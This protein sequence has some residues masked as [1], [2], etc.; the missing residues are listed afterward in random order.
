MDDIVRGLIEFVATNLGNLSPVAWY[1]VVAA[2]ILTIL[3]IIIP[4]AF[5]MNR[6]Y[7]SL[8]EDRLDKRSDL[9]QLS[10]QRVKMLEET[11]PL[12]ALEK[13]SDKQQKT[14]DDD[15]LAQLIDNLEIEDYRFLARIGDKQ[16][17][18]EELQKAVM[19]E[20]Y[21]YSTL[22]LNKVENLTDVQEELMQIGATLGYLFGLWTGLNGLLFSID[23]F[24]GPVE[25]G[26]RG[27]KIEHK[28]PTAVRQ[29][30]FQKLH[31]S[32]K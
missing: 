13:E 12:D 1:V 19:E 7:R 21:I 18:L 29:R 30:I 4:L 9:L 3:I 16:L 11:S 17:D 14:L 31:A 15:L 6:Y 2:V 23:I 28:L 10:E 25:W 5:A 26:A 32:S 22:G 8:Y 20:T 24:R 27:V